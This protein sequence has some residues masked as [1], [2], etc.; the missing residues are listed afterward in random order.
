MQNYVEECNV[1]LM[2]KIMI[3]SKKNSSRSY[4]LYIRLRSYNCVSLRILF[5]SPLTWHENPVPPFPPFTNQVLIF[6]KL[7]M[8]ALY[9]VLYAFKKQLEDKQCISEASR[10]LP[11]YRFAHV[12]RTLRTQR[13]TWKITHD[14]GTDCHGDGKEGHFNQKSKL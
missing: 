13:C 1:C 8:H 4:T 11:Y 10:D 5:S 6:F 2:F 3:W 7:R 14:G 9:F 12:G